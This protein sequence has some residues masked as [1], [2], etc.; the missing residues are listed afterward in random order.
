MASP[1]P[2]PSLGAS[3]GPAPRKKILVRKV[4]TT[5]STEPSSKTSAIDFGGMETMAPTQRQTPRPPSTLPPPAAPASESAIAPKG[6]PVGANG[7]RQDWAVLG[8]VGRGAHLAFSFPPPP[9][10]SHRSPCLFQVALYNGTPPPSFRI[11]PGGR[12]LAARRVHRQL[13]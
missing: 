2:A 3:Q 7:K 1:P 11:L 4:K 13:T 8:D 6:P 9:Q 12:G 5:I 10:N